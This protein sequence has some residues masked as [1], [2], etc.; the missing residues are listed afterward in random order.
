[1]ALAACGLPRSGPSKADFLGDGPEAA[2]DVF[3]VPVTDPVIR[4]TAGA[5][6]IGFP[7]AFTSAG[8]VGA[9]VIRPGDGL[10]LG[11][12]ENVDDGLL[13]RA[14]QGAT[15][16]EA[17][18][19]DDAG[20]IFVPYAGR[21]KAAGLTPEG[22]RAL[23]TR[24][25]ADQ[26]PDPQ[27]TVARRAGDGAAVSVLGD[28]GAQGVYP[29]ERPTRKLTGMLAQAGGVQ[30]PAEVARVTLRR[31]SRSGRAWLT[32]IYADPRH[33]IALRP[34]DVLVVERDSR[35]FVALGAT[36][37]QQRVAFDRQRLTALEAIAQAGG[38]SSQLADPEG[39][40]VLRNETAAIANRVLGRGD[41]AGPQRIVY[42]IDLTA[43]GGLFL[44]RDFTIRD[45]DSIYVTEAPYV[46]FQKA[47]QVLTGSAGAVNS[48]NSLSGN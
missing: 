39:V 10:T 22:L 46:G 48:V 21:L 20:F 6:G 38:L 16:L 15:A 29:I 8:A 32:D 28:V 41:L 2:G 11:I 37:G 19:V 12:W 33:D 36:G 25:L 1:M 26:T 4:A 27:V 17:V 7:A 30:A 35:S 13:A 34:G 43:P 40:F 23:I 42:A 44:A 24:R 31:G 5:P 18:Q 14:G 45:G 3:V 9:D 47:L